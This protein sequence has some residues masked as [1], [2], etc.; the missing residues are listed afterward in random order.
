MLIEL[1]EKGLNKNVQL[2]C[3]VCDNAITSKKLLCKVPGAEGEIG[4]YVNPHG[5]FCYYMYILTSLNIYLYFRVVHQ[6]VTISS[7]N[8]FSAILYGRPDSRDSWFPGFAW[9]IACCSRCGSHLGWK[10]TIVSGHANGDLDT[11]TAFW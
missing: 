2:L 11:L 1:L 10:F 6:T 3:V 4:A 5:Y 8:P 9:T 7:I